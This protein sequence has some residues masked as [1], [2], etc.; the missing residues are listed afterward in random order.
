MVVIAV[1]VVLLSLVVPGANALWTQ[2]RIADAENTLQGLLLNARMRAMQADGRETGLLFYLDDF[3]VQRVATI[4]QAEPDSHVW[5]DVFRITG[6]RDQTMPAPMRAVPRYVAEPDAIGPSD[7]HETFSFEELSGNSFLNPPRNSYPA[8]RHRNFFTVVYSTR[9][10]IRPWRDVLLIDLDV[11]V[12]GKGDR[13][14]LFVGDGDPDTVDPDEIA[15]WYTQREGPAV[16]DTT[17]P[18]PARSDL[19]AQPGELAAINFPSVDGVL[20]YDDKEMNRLRI[21][22]PVTDGKEF[23]TYLIKNAQPFYISRITG[24]VIV[25]PVGGTQ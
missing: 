7:D 10:E 1:A 11:N 25:G 14:G 18:S 15:K 20:V 16:F 17:R 23:R 13:T 5:A 4:E 22:N 24:S 9:G 3:G 12:D 19:I 6:D 2:R 8:Q 21:G